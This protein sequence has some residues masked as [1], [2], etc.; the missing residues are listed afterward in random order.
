[1]A[2]LALLVLA[3]AGLQLLGP[4]I[5]ARFIDAAQ[6]ASVP[7]RA[8][9]ILAV[10]YVGVAVLAYV[11]GALAGYVGEGVGWT[12]TNRLRVDLARHCLSLDLAFHQ[13]HTPGALVER[14][15]GDAA[16]LAD[17]FAQFAVRLG[18]GLL[19]LVG[20]VAVATVEVG[21]FGLGLGVFAG[22]CVWLVRVAQ[23]RSVPAFAEEREASAALSGFWNE[24]GGGLED[25]AANRGGAHM[26]DRYARLQRRASR[27]DLVSQTL[28]TSV[29][30]VW[31]VLSA[32]GTV[33]VLA[34]GAL[35]LARG[36]ISLGTVYLLFA[37]TSRLADLLYEVA[38][39]FDTLQ[40]ATASIGR[41]AALQGRTSSVPDGPGVALPPGPLAVAFDGVSFRYTPAQPVLTDVSFR[42]A[43]GETLG[44]VGR[45]GS[46]KSTIAR[47]LARFATPDAGT[48]S[49]GGYDIRQARAADLRR[50]IGFVPQ[51]V[52]LLAA[53]LRDN[54]ALFDPAI[55]DAALVAAIEQFGLGAWLRA[56]PQGLDTQLDPGGLSAGEA[57]LLACVRVA[58]R[59]PQL[60]VLDE[61]SSRLDPVSERAL[62]RAIATLLRGRTAIIIAHRLSTLR[63]VD[64]IIMLE[65]GRIV[66][67]GRRAD[68]ERDPRSRYARL[69]SAAGGSEVIV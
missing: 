6:S 35:L 1:V 9:P 69:L 50:R 53:P 37:Y 38:Y 18:A 22:V 58:L 46:G 12:A 48:V 56:L 51:E 60:L 16:V 8:L 28:S 31:Q 29:E 17:F 21:P 57:Q 66:E 30:W 59:D 5:I 33:L 43:P 52:R 47:L 67:Y 45:T 15:D 68:L 62:H 10:T 36:A 20:L 32:L 65:G 55:S 49:I 64:R 7:A 26:R 41:I 34:V 23:R 2:L 3:T 39:Q 54:L 42:L 19:F 24:L 44:L 14:V 63:E 11:I 13:E 61:A 40:Q 25:V 27:A 4:Q